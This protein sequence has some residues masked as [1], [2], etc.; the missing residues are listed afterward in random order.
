M[1]KDGAHFKRSAQIL[2]VLGNPYRLNIVVLLL[3]GEKN[4]TE[5]NKSIKVS[6]PALSQHLSKLRAE[7]LLGARRDQRQIFYYLRSPHMER[8][9]GIMS[10][11]SHDLK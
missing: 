3:T 8:L 4:V 2:K 5:L 6:Q 11:I 7:G 9:L 1:F 10:D